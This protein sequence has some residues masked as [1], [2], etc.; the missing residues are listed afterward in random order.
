VVKRHKIA[1]SLS[2]Y[3][4]TY[5]LAADGADLPVS[6]GVGVVDEFEVVL[7]SDYDAAINMLRA[8]E[9]SNDYWRR[10]RD[11]FIEDTA[12]HE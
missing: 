1:Y 9:I 7:A 10:R 11:A 8:I 2:T 4:G 6:L 3:S 5:Q 12:R